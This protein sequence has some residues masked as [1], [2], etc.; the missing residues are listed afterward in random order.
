MNAAPAGSITACRPSGWIQKVIFTK[1][2][3]N[4]V[5]FVKPS[6]GDPVLLIVDGH[7]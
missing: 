2:F 3:D 6:A 5:H 1:L 4:F 7:Y